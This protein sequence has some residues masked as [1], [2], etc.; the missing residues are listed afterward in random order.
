MLVS[1][2]Y[3]KPT[4]CKIASLESDT[5]RRALWNPDNTHF[6]TEARL[7][8]YSQNQV[9]CPPL[10][11]PRATRVVLPGWIRAVGLCRCPRR[12]TLPHSL[13]EQGVYFQGSDGG[14]LSGGSD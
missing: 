11:Q 14:W 12:R 4:E 2:S 8:S 5:P 3:L 13:S 1:I 6:S 9:T 10:D 7:F